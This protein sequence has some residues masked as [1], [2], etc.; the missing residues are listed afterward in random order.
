MT[1][2][3]ISPGLIELLARHPLVEIEVTG[4]WVYC[5]HKETGEVVLHIVEHE[6]NRLCPYHLQLANKPQPQIKA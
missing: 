5:V 4:G 2:A 6:W 1:T 3:Q